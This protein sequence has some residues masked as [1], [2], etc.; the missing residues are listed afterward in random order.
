MFNTAETISKKDVSPIN[1]Q[2][3]HIDL[4]CISI[5]SSERYPHHDT[6][7]QQVV[8]NASAL[9]EVGVPVELVLPSQ[10][11]GLLKNGYRLDRA[12]YDYYN[13]PQGLK[14]REFRTVPAGDFRFEKIFH[15]VFATLHA[16]FRKK[17]QVIYT[18]NRTV[19]LLAFLF[20][21]NL[22]FE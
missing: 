19:A 11:L 7:T 20:K 4:P 3:L 15:S 14:I 13:V 18:R 1:A 9:H 22:L 17:T 8:K 2:S 10:F 12:V 6:N 5:I 21:K 16:I